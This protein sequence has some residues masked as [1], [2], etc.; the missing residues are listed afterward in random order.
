MPKAPLRKGS[1]YFTFDATRIPGQ[2]GVLR[3]QRQLESQL[4]KPAPW[5]A[6][7]YYA[8]VGPRRSGRSVVEGLG[9]ERAAA[10]DWA[11][12]VEKI[13]RSSPH[14]TALRT[15]LY[16]RMRDEAVEPQM[17]NV[18]LRRTLAYWG[19][20]QKPKQLEKAYKLQGRRTWRGMQISIEN[21]KGSVRRWKDSDGNTGESKMHWPYGYIR[22]T[23]GADGDHYDCYIGPNEQCT[24]AYVVHQHHPETGKYDEDKVM[25]GWDSAAKAKVAYLKQYD[26]PRFF[27]SMT[28]MTVEDFKAK[29][30]GGAKVVK[31]ERFHLDTGGIE[32]ECAGYELRTNRLL[33]KGGT[34]KYLRRLPT[35]DAKRPWRYIYHLGSMHHGRQPADVG[36]KIRVKHGE[37]EGHYEVT[38]THDTGHVTIRHDESG[39]EQKVSQGE[40]HEMFTGEHGEGLDEHH[41]KLK[42][43][44]KHGSEKQ[45]ERAAKRLADF[46]KRH[47]RE[48]KPETKPEPAAPEAAAKAPKHAINTFLEQHKLP[49]EALLQSFVIMGEERGRAA[50]QKIAD[51]TGGTL[52]Q[53]QKELAKEYE[54]EMFEPDWLRKPT[55]AKPET[56]KPEPRPEPKPKPKV[57]EPEEPVPPKRKERRAKPKVAAMRRRSDR[58][59]KGGKDATWST[60]LESSG[61]EDHDFVEADRAYRAW[62]QGKGKK[63]PPW[64]GGELDAVNEALDL[65][66]DKRVSSALEGFYKLTAGAKTWR[67]VLQRLDPFRDV[68]GLKVLRPSEE[69]VERH[70]EQDLRE[71]YRRY[72][73]ETEGEKSLPWLVRDA[74]AFYQRIEEHLVKSDQSAR[75]RDIGRWCRRARTPQSE[76]FVLE[77]ELRKA[78]PE[79]FHVQL[80]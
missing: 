58:L 49:M 33:V 65:R 52:E 38:Q 36:E 30:L 37:T 61:I 39:H 45:K 62:R 32:V 7:R 35:G 53:V 57:G 50:L 68:P 48:A 79:R 73:E 56:S 76:R 23:E 75:L 4:R 13:V 77:G 44:A 42:Q 69:V 11:Q 31:A 54:T 51:A 20:A 74:A 43:A 6:E 12:Y 59:P 21:R 5:S 28:T 15:S 78:Q 41:A 3:H 19:G 16:S 24:N 46:E 9:L 17:R 71:Q 70:V 64:K 8:D 22:K 63:P 10:N 66:G 1:L 2:I 26:D 47:D 60:L 18:L 55:E 29:V 14:Q 40:L 72:S 34:H 27:G 67:E 25:L 80:P